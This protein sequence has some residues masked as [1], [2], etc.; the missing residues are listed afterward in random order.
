MKKLQK[1]LDTTSAT[2]TGAGVVSG[3]E[4]EGRLELELLE[5]PKREVEAQRL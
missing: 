5:G 4:E 2:V 3:R 1:I